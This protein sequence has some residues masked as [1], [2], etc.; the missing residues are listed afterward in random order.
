MTRLE[1]ILSE[2]CH[3]NCD[4]DLEYDPEDGHYHVDPPP[5]ACWEGAAYS[6]DPAE[7]FL[8]EENYSIKDLREIRD[9][10][11]VMLEEA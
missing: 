7:M 1:K 9:W 6:H 10:L 3:K 2:E 11:N 4:L 5:P 8:G